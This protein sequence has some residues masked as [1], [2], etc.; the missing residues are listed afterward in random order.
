MN[1]DANERRLSM[2]AFLNSPK[3]PGNCESSSSSYMVSSSRVNPVVLKIIDAERRT[4]TNFWLQLFFRHIETVFI[5]HSRWFSSVRVWFFFFNAGQ[6]VALAVNLDGERGS[7]RVVRPIRM[8]RGI[9]LQQQQAGR[10]ARLGRQGHCKLFDMEGWHA[11]S[12]YPENFHKCLPKS[13]RPKMAPKPTMVL[14]TP[15]WVGCRLDKI[16]YSYYKISRNRL[17][18]W[19]F[20]QFSRF[21]IFSKKN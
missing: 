2:G 21:S 20:A 19:R 12:V 9:E 1:H 16:T 11:P 6:F 14:E 17:F 7:E 8:V 3:A 15:F 5:A 13:P 4:N 18:W 10:V